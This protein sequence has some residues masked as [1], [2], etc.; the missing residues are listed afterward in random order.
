MSLHICPNPHNIQPQECNGNYGLWEIMKF[1]VC[2]LVTT[3]ALP[4]C[5]VLTMR[6][7]V[8]VLGQGGYEKY[9]YLP[10]NFAMNPKPKFTFL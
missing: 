8:H 2:S 1:N 10:F 9:L 7:S 6:E 5:G 4:W 3:N